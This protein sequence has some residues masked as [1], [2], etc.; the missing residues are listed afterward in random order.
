MTSKG[1]AARQARRLAQAQG[2][3]PDLLTAEELRAEITDLAGQLDHLDNN[4][5]ERLRRGTQIHSRLR[6]AN[7]S[8][9]AL[10]AQGPPYPDR[11]LL[12]DLHALTNK[13][14]T[15][16]FNVSDEEIAQMHQAIK[17]TP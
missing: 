16:V 3:D 1:R 8:L 15:D 17:G 9:K 11:S 6:H 13:V 5:K 4:P 10:N 2:S 7:N 14:L 12:T